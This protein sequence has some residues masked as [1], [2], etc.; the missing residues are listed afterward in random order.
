MPPGN[1]TFSVF[2]MK[3]EEIAPRLWW[4]TAPHP[5]WTPGAFRGGK[6]WKEDVSSYALVENGEL[7]LFD[8][9]VPRGE[10]E[11]FWKA[12]DG[13]VE[14]HGPPAILITVYWHA[15]SSQKI[16]ERYQG[17]TL[18][19][20]EPASRGLGNRVQYTDTF[21]GGDTLPGG[22]EALAMHHMNEAAFWL[23]GHRALVL[24]D[25][26]VGYDDRAELSPS[27]WLRKKETVEEQRASVQRAMER[28]PDR[29]LLTHGGPTDPSALEV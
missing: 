18:W 23:P 29:L 20:H 22:V 6:G 16:L 28:N 5:S 12:L 2:E 9:L 13:D 25:S 8:P 15:R 10:E 21:E 19:A 7:V 24:G 3:M 11:A 26:V 4:W 14:H 17:S 1:R 27:S